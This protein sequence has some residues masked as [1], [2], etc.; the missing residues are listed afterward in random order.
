MRVSGVGMPGS[1]GRDEGPFLL[2]PIPAPGPLTAVWAG[3]GVTV[4][5]AQG[6]A[7]SLFPL[8]SESQAHGPCFL[9]PYVILKMALSNASEVFLETGHG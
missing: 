8:L 7:R 4:S 1:G 2:V 3:R 6:D 9:Q 5:D